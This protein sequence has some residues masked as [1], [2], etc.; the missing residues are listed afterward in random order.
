M[1][2]SITTMV[3]LHSLLAFFLVVL[4]IGSSLGYLVFFAVGW[5]CAVGLQHGHIRRSLLMVLGGGVLTCLGCVPFEFFHGDG[6][7]L[8]G[9]LCSTVGLYIALWGVLPLLG[10]AYGKLV[11]RTFDS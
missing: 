3:V 4:I 8:A 2:Y 7:W 10:C 5:V 11:G 1:R 6:L 9:L